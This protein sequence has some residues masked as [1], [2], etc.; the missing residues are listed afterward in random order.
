M[1]LMLACVRCWDTANIWFGKKTETPSNFHDIVN[2]AIVICMQYTCC[3]T[4]SAAVCPVCPSTQQK[5]PIGIPYL[6]KSKSSVRSGL[7]LIC[8][9][10]SFFRWKA[11]SNSNFFVLKHPFHYS[12]KS[13][14]SISHPF[15]GPLYTES[16]I[17]VLFWPKKILDSACFYI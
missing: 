16:K 7:F 9:L 17:L 11:L 8:S 13:F 2:Y 5:C 4:L 12:V 6:W 15:S 1:A 14:T 10:Y 3:S